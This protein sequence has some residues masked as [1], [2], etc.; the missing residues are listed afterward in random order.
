MS[1]S[2]LRSVVTVTLNPTIDKVMEVSG[3]HIGGHLPG[4]LRSRTPSGKAFNVSRALGLLGID[5]T[6]AGWMG[7]DAMEFFES[8]ARAARVTPRF[9]PLEDATRENI[10]LLDPVSRTETHIRDAG[11]SV[12][13]EDIGRLRS[14]LSILSH[15]QAVIVFSGSTPPG[16]SAEGFGELV[17]LCIERGARVA[18]DTSREPIR[19]AAGKALWLIKPNLLELSD[20]TGRPLPDEAAVLNAAR[21]LNERIPIVVVTAGERGAYCFAEG[22]GFHGHVSLPREH[23]RSTV[24]CGDAFMAGFLAGMCFDESDVESAFRNALTVAASSALQELPAV[25]S[26]E[27]LQVVAPRVEL[28]SC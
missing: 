27:D 19:V 10:T 18:V 17:D 22:R 2:S 1:A 28:A 15:G 13:P 25:F 26:P 3:L 16:L 20:A 12:A 23:I 24:G 11:P 9:V 21:E 4:R 5:N 14:E 6:A 8:A 7:R